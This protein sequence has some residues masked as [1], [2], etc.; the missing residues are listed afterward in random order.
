MDRDRIAYERE[1]QKAYDERRRTSEDRRPDLSEVTPRIST[2]PDMPTPSGAGPTGGTMQAEGAQ[3]G[4]TFEQTGRETFGDRPRD[5]DERS[6]E[7][8]IDDR[9]ARI[10]DDR[11]LTYDER[12]R[13]YGEESR[14]SDRRSNLIW[15]GWLKN[16]EKREIS[17]GGPIR[18]E[19]RYTA[20]E[21]FHD[22]KGA[23]CKEG[24]RV[25]VP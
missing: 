15:S 11:K 6:H 8:T 5:Y 25:I 1:H 3:Q 23:W 12:A 22:N 4:G 10:P 18:Y 14:L 19:Y 7:R 21:R 13:L 17:S 20:D 16:G 2:M 24:R 9:R